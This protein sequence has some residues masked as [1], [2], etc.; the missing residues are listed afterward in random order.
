MIHEYALTPDAFEATVAGLRNAEHRFEDPRAPFA[1]GDEVQL[2][3]LTTHNPRR[4][5]FTGRLISRRI[6]YI[7]RATMGVRYGYA[8]LHTAPAE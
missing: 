2:A 5:E 4:R 3:E 1:V 7:E 8:L 6:A